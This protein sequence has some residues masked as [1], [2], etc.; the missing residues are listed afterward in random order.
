MIQYLIVLFIP[1]AKP[2][3]RVNSNSNSMIPP[4]RKDKIPEP[5]RI[6][7]TIKITREVINV[8]LNKFILNLRETSSFRERRKGSKTLP[9]DGG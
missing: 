1:Q 8:F 4:G 9:L 6:Y 7:T 3:L 5:L 2:K